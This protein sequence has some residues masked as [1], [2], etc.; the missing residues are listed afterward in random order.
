MDRVTQQNAST[1]SRIAAKPP[2][3]L[4]EQASRLTSG[5][6]FPHGIATAGDKIIN[7]RMRLSADAQSAITPRPLAAGMMRTETF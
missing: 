1:G 3:H 5:I 6:G 7:P 2:P 4:E